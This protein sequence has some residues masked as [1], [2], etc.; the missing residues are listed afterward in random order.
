MTKTIKIPIQV[1]LIASILLAAAGF[2]SNGANGIATVSAA[3]SSHVYLPLVTN[4][5]SGPSVDWPQLGRDAQR[6][7][8][9]PQEVDPPYCYAWKWNAVPIAS[10]VQPV[11]K[12]GILYVGGMDGRLYA[13]DATTGQALWSYLTGGPIRNTAAV[14]GNIVITGSY[15]GYTYALNASTGS[16][17]WKTLTGSSATAPLIDESRGRVYVAS[18]YGTLTALNV[19]NGGAVWQYNAGAAILTSPSLSA[20]GSLVIFGDEAVQA[21]AVNAN[22]GS[23]VWQTALQGESLAERYPVVAGDAV[24]F[25]SEPYYFFHDL[26]QKYGDD[27]MDKA[28]SLLSDWNADWAKVKPQIVSFLNS[29][30]SMQ[31]FFVLNTSNGSSR[32]T[33][34]VLYTYGDNDVPNVPVIN[35][36]GQAFVTYR[37]R[38]GIQT[39]N[40]SVHVSSKY[41][42]ELGQMNLSSLDVT[43]LRNTTA[44]T[45]PLYGGP[46]FRMT[47]DEPAMLTMGG[48]ILWVDNWERLGG[49]NVSTGALVYA[50]NV[51]NNWPACNGQCGSPAPNP[52]YP[53]SGNK[54]DLGYPF[55]GPQV[56]EGYGRSGVVVANHMVYWKASASGLAAI[57]HSDSSQCSAPKVWQDS[58][59][60][61]GQP[62]TYSQPSTRPLQNYVTTDLTGVNANPPADLVSR[63]RSEVSALLQ[64]ANGNHLMPFFLER[65]MSTTQVWPYNSSQPDIPNISYMSHGNVFWQDPGDLL[66]AM[67][68]AYPYLDS[69]LQASVKTYMTQE[70]GRYPPLSSL[71][72]ND[73]SHD[74]LRTGSPREQYTVVSGVRTQLNNWPPMAANMSAIY[75]LWLW[76]KN[77]GDWTYASAHW[78]SVQSLFNARS[79]SMK[80]YADIAGAIGYYRLADHFGKTTER[81]AAMTAAVNAM[82]AGL[83]FSTYVNRAKNDYLDPNGT[84]GTP[85]GLYAP[86]FYGITPEVG[87]YLSEQMGGQAQSL[88]A[89]IESLDS[90]GRGFLWWYLTRAGGHAE[91]GETAFID[92][93]AAWSHFIG[94]AYIFRDSQ[95]TLRQWLDRP[96]TPGDLYSIEKIVATIQAP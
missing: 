61:I 15:D 79:S 73:T 4:F 10:I 74:W 5:Y 63:L 19:N 96:W 22:S 90:S 81:D 87:L 84:G 47:S 16:L 46:P 34:P 3:G 85:T 92:P 78:S 82:Q 44:Y 11:V 75:A 55:P 18:D 80:Y 71:P 9:S 6:T 58:G 45:I 31:S 39:D 25:R 32:G 77:T 2:A 57:A 91:S 70:M 76:S 94:H 24:I 56:T 36:S 54:N 30:P 52:F 28:G 65:G 43:G 62:P 35:A 8:Y 69:S 72:Y 27:V 53:L 21:I 49:I 14:T 13:R 7:N 88:L 59:G 68:L 86:V 42:A 83:S 37:A 41:D 66:Y 64:A 1:L 26:L 48:S 12:G 33:A 23:K 40:G 17:V 50:G 89:S 60:A 38:H 95:S 67:A 20:D 51:S 29:N 93:Y